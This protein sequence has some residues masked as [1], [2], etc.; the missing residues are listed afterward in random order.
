MATA[1]GGQAEAPL[2]VYEESTLA[3]AT[4]HF[5]GGV[6]LPLDPEAEPKVCLEPLA[7]PVKSG[8]ATP[9]SPPQIAVSEA[10]EQKEAAPDALSKDYGSDVVSG[11]VTF[12]NGLG[13]DTP[14]AAADAQKTGIRTMHSN[15]L[16]VMEASWR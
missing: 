10:D 14:D 8:E 6:E 11:E 5:L 9:P 3:S 4:E 7:S 13:S 15:P 12:A 16:H 1:S 2:P